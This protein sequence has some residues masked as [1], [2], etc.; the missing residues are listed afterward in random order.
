MNG[1]RASVHLGVAWSHGGRVYNPDRIHAVVK[2]DDVQ[3]TRTSADEVTWDGP[4]K[5]LCDDGPASE[6]RTGWPNS[7]TCKKCRV[8]LREQ[9]V[10]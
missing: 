6:K 9:G 2:P 8:K 4:W 1:K 10:L 3:A 5:R 7:V